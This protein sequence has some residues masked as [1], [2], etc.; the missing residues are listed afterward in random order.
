M[1]VPTNIDPEAVQLLEEFN[2]LWSDAERAFIEARDPE[3][4][5]TEEYRSRFKARVTYEDLRD[6]GFV[7]PV[8]GREREA[9]FGWLRE[10]LSV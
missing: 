2:W 7:G 10:R 6:H 5:T 3:Q 9:G 8:S 4:E 1:G